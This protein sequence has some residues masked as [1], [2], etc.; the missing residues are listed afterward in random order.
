M[1]VLALILS[2]WAGLA[3]AQDYVVT[4][5]ILSDEDFYRLVACGAAPGGECGMPY[6]RWS[7]SRAIAIRV[8]LEAPIAGYPDALYDQLSDA[9][10]RAIAEINSVGARLQLQRVAKGAGEDILIS[11]LNVGDG[12]AVRGSGVPDLEGA[13][14]G[15]A[16]VYVWWDG[17]RNLTDGRILMA[18]DLPE[19][20]VYPVLLEE[21]TQAMGFLNDIRNPLYEDDS[22]FSEDSNSVTRLGRQDR[23]AILR[24]YP[25]G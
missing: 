19:R 14:M 12:E 13:I 7:D 16:Y 5:G 15:A 20:E 21:L 25:P 3:A 1:K 11:G 2:L 6:V 24:H 23:A 10:D 22:V 17:L 18:N 8:R 9:V 4:N